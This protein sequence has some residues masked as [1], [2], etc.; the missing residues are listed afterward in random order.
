MYLNQPKS[1]EVKGSVLNEDEIKLGE[2]RNA[3]TF[4]PCV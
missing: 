1:N 2:W 3:H 4:H